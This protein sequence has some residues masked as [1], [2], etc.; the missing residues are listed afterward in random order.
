MVA[1]HRLA[2]TSALGWSVTQQRAILMVNPMVVL[3]PTRKILRSLPISGPA[4]LRSDTALG[5]WYVNRLVVDS[6]PL[7]LFVSAASLLPMLVPARDVRGLPSRLADLVEARLR[8]CG[9][10]NRTIE[11]EKRAMSPVTIGAT[12]DRSVLGIMVDFA[13]SIPYYLEPGRWDDATLQ[14]VEAKLAETP[15]YAGRSGAQTVFPE[16]KAPALLRARWEAH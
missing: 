9:I 4:P 6:R 10:A 13:K 7:L 16:E 14:F 11:L 3:R 15:C 2:V 8:R 5:D 1:T 12:M